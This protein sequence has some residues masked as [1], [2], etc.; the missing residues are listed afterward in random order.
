MNDPD[1]NNRGMTVLNCFRKLFIS[2]IN[3]RIYSF[4]DTSN[5]LGI[6]QSGFRNGHST[7]DRG[8]VL[9]CVLGVYLQQKTDYFVHLLIIKGPLAV[10]SKDCCG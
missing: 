8:F 9:H 7:L 4:L 1:D 10:C 5:S 2:V 3:D 6:K